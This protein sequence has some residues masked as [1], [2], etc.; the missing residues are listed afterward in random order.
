MVFEIIGFVAV[1]AGLAVLVLPIWTFVRLHR[2]TQHIYELTAR[3]AAL[4]R[5]EDAR[6]AMAFVRQSAGAEAQAPQAPPP[7]EHA[8]EAVPPPRHVSEMPPVP[9]P[10][11]EQPRPIE[12][13]PPAVPTLAH[14]IERQIGGR[15]L[16]YAGLLI[17]LIGVSFFLKY[18]FDNEWVDARG[19]VALGV[20]AG[21]GL[22]GGG[23][24]LARRD[25]RT[26]GLALSGAGLA[27]LYLSV[28][29]ALAFYGLVDRVTAFALMGVVTAVGVW[30][31][32]RERAQSLGVIG[33]GGGFL[34]PFLVGGDGNA[35]LTL[36]TY[37]A[38]LV[39]AT[40]LLLYRHEWLGL[41]ALSFV[42]TFITIAGWAGTHYEDALWLRTLLFLT[43]FGG[44][45]VTILH[46]VRTMSGPWAT[47]VAVLLWTAPVAYHIAALVLTSDHP[48]AL[49]LY[50]IVFSAAAVGLTTDPHRPWIRLLAL[51]AAMTPLFGY[52][53]LPSGPSWMLANIVTI[54]VVSGVFLFACVDRV[55]RQEETLVTPDLITMHIAGLGL[56]GLL[57]QTS[58]PRFPELR[59]ILAVGVAAVAGGIWW[60]LRRRDPSAALNAAALALTLMA[61]AVAVQFDGRTVVI[62][63]AAEGALIAWIGIR[64]R[65]A[66]FRAGGLLLWLAAIAQLA[67]GYFA[68]P[69]GFT[70]IINERSLA[71]LFVLLTGYVL[72]WKVGSHQTPEGASIRAAVH[73]VSSILTL[74]WISAEIKSYWA[75]RYERPQAYLYEELML[76]LGWGLYGAAA[77]V[78]GLWRS[79]APLRYIGITVIAMTVLKVFF[80][81]LWDLGGIYRVVGFL[82]LGVLLVLVS[83]LYQRTRRA[84]PVGDVA[85]TG[86]DPVATQDR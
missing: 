34:T 26:F 67:D 13:A 54:I 61:I 78:V 58:E 77:V 48:P 27:V 81:D 36:F 52:L 64:A 51:L 2:A 53:V 79:Y 46:K 68:T 74:V 84:A 1:L 70:A 37:D 33:I 23:L 76:S 65:N 14:D 56:Y 29:A 63:W 59:G 17:L 7:P 25:L 49:H 75:I 8:A 15:W 72:A 43:L 55:L 21:A 45:F 80:V 69:V 18:A 42:M 6:K 60:L 39:T 30:L 3:V 28:Y 62:G 31:A 66:L 57:Y 71:T 86:G 44:L 41:P 9:P 73:V 83:Y 10:V 20:L 22:I 35:Q 47:M 16:L 32:D 24:R 38:I 40:L 85:E 82:T 11:P 12:P 4:E 19:R 5:A 50:L